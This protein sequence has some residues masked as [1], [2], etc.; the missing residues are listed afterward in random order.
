MNYGLFEHEITMT[1]FGDTKNLV[2]VSRDPKL[3]EID[4]EIMYKTKPVKLNSL[5]HPE[6][7]QEHLI[8]KNT[9]YSIGETKVRSVQSNDFR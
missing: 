5:N 7:G 8:I 4:C 3:L 1:E 2:A 6:K 9:Y